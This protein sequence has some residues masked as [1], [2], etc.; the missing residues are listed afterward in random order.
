MKSKLG[1]D[2]VSPRGFVYQCG[3]EAGHTVCPGGHI[4]DVHAGACVAA[5]STDKRWAKVVGFPVQ[6]YSDNYGLECYQPAC[7]SEDKCGPKNG[8]KVCAE[9]KNCVE[10]NHGGVVQARA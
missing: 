3:P 1:K 7:A 5:A 6:K 4:C 8:G 10:D 9:G 2:F